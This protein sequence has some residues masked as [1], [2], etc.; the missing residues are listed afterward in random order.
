MSLSLSLEDETLNN[1]L[2]NDP[3]INCIDE[4]FPSLNSNTQ[5]SYYSPHELK[6]VLF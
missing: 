5:S 2:G 6:N 3:D 1:Y 4:L